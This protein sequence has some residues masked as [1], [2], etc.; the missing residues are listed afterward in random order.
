MVRRENQIACQRK[1]ERIS[2]WWCVCG[3]WKMVSKD[4]PGAARL[5]GCRVMMEVWF[6]SRH[7]RG[8]LRR[9]RRFWHIAQISKMCVKRLQG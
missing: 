9:L 1:K 4:S 5:S 7:W 3:K 6:I 8:Y 2:H